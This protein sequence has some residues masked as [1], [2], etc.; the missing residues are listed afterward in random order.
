MEEWE[1]VDVIP[2]RNK[3]TPLLTD[4]CFAENNAIVVLHILFLK[5]LQSMVSEDKSIL[6][7]EIVF[8]VETIKLQ[9]VASS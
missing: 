7:M 2:A 1:G 9:Y 6:D 4:C 8:I 3:L 5:F